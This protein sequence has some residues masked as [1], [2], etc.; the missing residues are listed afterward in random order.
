MFKQLGT[1]RMLPL[2]IFIGSYVDLTE[3]NLVNVYQCMRCKLTG[4]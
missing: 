3:N 1:F 4:F 2:I